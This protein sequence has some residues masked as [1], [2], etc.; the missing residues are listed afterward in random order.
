M[1]A[2]RNI[3]L[4]QQIRKKALFKFCMTKS[5]RVIND[6]YKIYSDTA[7]LLYCYIPKAASTTWKRVFQILNGNFT[8]EKIL[9]IDKNEV[10]FFDC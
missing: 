1:E 4:T 5:T 7:K 9:T 3:L 2:A 8:N 6:N 10:S